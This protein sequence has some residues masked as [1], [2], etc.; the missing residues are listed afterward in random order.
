MIPALRTE[1][2]KLVT[3]RLWWVLLISMA[4]LMAFFAA[5][6]GFVAT[7]PVEEGGMA[8]PPGAPTDPATVALSV[9]SLAAGIGYVF[10]VIVGALS[11]TGEFRSMTITPT[12]LAEPRRTLLI[13]A[14]LVGAVPV[15]LVFGLAGTAATVL[16]GAATLELAGAEAMLGD[17]EVQRG[18]AL[19]VVALTLW[20]L[21]GVGFGTM[22][23]HQVAAIVVIIAYNQLVEPLVR[24]FLGTQD[25]ARETVSFLPGAA[26]DAVVGSSLFAT[27]GSVELL[28]WWQGLLVLVAYAAVFAVIGRVT[29][30]RRDI[31]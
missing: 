21:I 16:G 18:L 8:G 23:T 28:E 19:S 11:V 6:M 30:F 1:Y 5:A 20:T 12:L 4:V 10:P 13:G 9:Y 24:A 3:T 27:M 31:T 7:V 15:G 22:L 25:W 14:K 29:T 17:S 26:A 2:R